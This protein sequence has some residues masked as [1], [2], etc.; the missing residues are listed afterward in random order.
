MKRVSVVTSFLQ[1]DDRVLIVR[2]SDKVRTMQ[3]QWAGISG[4]IENESPLEAA[5]REIFE[6]TAIKK[7]DL[8]LVREGGPLD[9]IDE[10]RETIWVVHPF[11]FRTR[12][13]K[14]KLDWEHDEYRWILPY[15]ITKYDT[16]LMLKET[17]Q[18]VAEI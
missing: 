10:E 18:A 11:L 12:N 2:R 14:I 3:H 13:T 15:E 4:S 6:E 1:H 16:V 8:E 9:V 17:L 5:F 7:D